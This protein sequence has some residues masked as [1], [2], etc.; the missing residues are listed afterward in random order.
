LW[1]YNGCIQWVWVPPHIKYE[2]V[3]ECYKAVNTVRSH[4]VPLQ[5]WEVLIKATAER[6]R[7][8]PCT[9]ALEHHAEKN[10][11]TSNQ[12]HFQFLVLM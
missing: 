9:D 7:A 8:L 2:R 4:N 1:V 3:A 6:D 10:D 11:P 12:C 5:E